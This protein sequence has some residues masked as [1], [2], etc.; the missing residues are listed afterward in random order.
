MAIANYFYNS[1]T[2][3][4]VA[5]FGTYFNQL[6]IER[7]NLQGAAIQRMVVPISYAPFQ[8]ILTRLEQDPEFAKKSGIT[9]PR[10]SFELTSMAY[11]ADRKIS[12]TRKIRKTAK[13]ETTNSRNFIYAGTPYNLDFSLYIMAKYNEDAV[14]LLEQILPFFNPEFTSTVRLIDDIEPIDV[15]LILNSVDT[16]ELYEADFTERRSILYT[17]NFTMKSWFFG[18]EKEKKVIKFVDVREWTSM[19]PPSENYDGQITVQPGMT[20]EGV[21]TSVLTNT[22]DYSLID[23]DDNWDYVVTRD[24]AS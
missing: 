12:P 4:Y 7:Q 9:L 17:L 21:A 6:T 23:F 24:D 2:R 18:P 19:D 11:D 8:K 22:V 10:M 15:P 13:D 3:K 14:K 20:S 16:E 1:T 5:L